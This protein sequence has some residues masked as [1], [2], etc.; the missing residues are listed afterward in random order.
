L[1]EKARCQKLLQ[2][3]HHQCIP[4]IAPSL[5]NVLTAKKARFLNLLTG[6]QGVGALKRAFYFALW[7]V[8]VF[9][10]AWKLL[11]AR[12]FGIMSPPQKNRAEKPTIGFLFFGSGDIIAP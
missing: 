3:T 10:H 11:S 2:V 9:F 7:H 5:K 6:K 4:T 1:P 8:L 12:I